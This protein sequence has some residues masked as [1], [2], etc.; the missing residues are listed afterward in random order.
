MLSGAENQSAALRVNALQVKPQCFAG[1]N[2]SIESTKLIDSRLT[3]SKMT[4]LPLQF[5]HFPDAANSVRSAAG[6]SVSPV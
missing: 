1:S 3:Y 4:E 2:N 5:H 6:S